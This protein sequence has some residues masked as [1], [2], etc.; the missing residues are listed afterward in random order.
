MKSP[1]MTTLEGFGREELV[2]MYEEMLLIRRFEE[3]IDDLF[4]E[5]LLTGTCH[6]GIGQ[7]AAAVGAAHGL[8]KDDWMS[9]THRGHGHFLAK[10]ADEKLVMAEM[11]GKAPGYSGGRGGSQHMAHLAIGFLGSNGITGGGIPIGTGAALAL[12]RRKSKQVVAVFMGDGAANQGVFH[13][14]LNMAALWKLP[15]VYLCENNRYAM[16]TPFE[17]AFATKTI[18]ERVR[19][20]GVPAEVVDGNEVLLVTQAVRSAAER[21]RQGKG[22][23]FIE[24]KTYRFCGH[25]KSDRCEYR[26][27]E[28]EKTHLARCPIKLL[29]E[30]LRTAGI[31]DEA[32]M[33]K[34]DERVRKRIEEAEAFA[35]SA[36]APDQ[37]GEVFT[38]P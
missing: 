9:S 3:R 24:L 1:E 33:A 11:F 4:A 27:E 29:G 17:K 34:I 23:S 14:S 20:F 28:E 13:E 18:A 36:P 5:G 16:S 12:A 15:V 25:S 6:L 38:E 19:G 26:S 8:A 2:R 7:E 22:P 37:K 21:A 10:G 35:R 31:L 30:R 32:G